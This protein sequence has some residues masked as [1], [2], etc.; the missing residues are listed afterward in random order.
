MRRFPHDEILNDRPFDYRGRFLNFTATRCDFAEGVEVE[1]VGKPTQINI[2]NDV[3]A[4]VGFHKSNIHPYL[5]GFQGYDC[6][7]FK[8]V[9][10]DDSIG[11]DTAVLIPDCIKEIENDEG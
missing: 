10:P 2:M 8:V 3:A 4:M 1:I 5:N 6:C 9:Q 7:G 11:S